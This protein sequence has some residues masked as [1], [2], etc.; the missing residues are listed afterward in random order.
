LWLLLFLYC[1]VEAAYVDFQTVDGERQ[2]QTQKVSELQKKLDAL[3][4][5]KLAGKIQE[6]NA[7]PLGKNDVDC[8]VTIVADIS[9]SGAPSV[10]RAMSLTIVLNSGKTVEGHLTPPPVGVTTLYS[11]K[12]K[13]SP[14][15][16]FP[17]ADFLPRKALDHPIPTGGEAVGFLQFVVQGATRNQV[18]EKGVT[19][20]L[21]FKD[22]MGKE[23]VAE[24]V[25]T[26][27]HKP[28]VVYQEPAD[29]RK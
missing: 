7:A 25:L 6:V 26:G 18:F 1:I 24:Y 22:F 28:Y 5:P 3:T 20:R 19:V 12:A 11:G 23:S 13:A 10:A 2:T 8:L 29:N 21:S 17:E 14:A 27:Q 9:N 16:T 15:E 4:V